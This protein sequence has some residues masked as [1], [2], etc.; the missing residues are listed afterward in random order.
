MMLPVVMV[1][2]FGIGC[3]WGRGDEGRGK[4]RGEG[5]GGR[6]RGGRGSGERGRDIGEKRYYTKLTV[7]VVLTNIVILIL[8]PL[9]SNRFRRQTDVEQI[10]INQNSNLQFG[11]TNLLVNLSSNATWQ[12]FSYY[13]Y[14]LLQTIPLNYS[15]SQNLDQ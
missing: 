10:L 6:G 15:R 12:F 5:G 2:A 8:Q 13:I 3:Q 4:G 1:C 7:I 9:K 11:S 14:I